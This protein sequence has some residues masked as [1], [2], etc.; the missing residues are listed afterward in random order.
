MMLRVQEKGTHV[1][2]ASLFYTVMGVLFGVYFVVLKEMGAHGA[3]LSG[4]INGL[5]FVVTLLCI[6]RPSLR[7]TFRTDMLK[8]SMK[9]S[10]PMIPQ[11]LGSI[12][13][14]YVDKLILGL[15]VPL[16]MIGLY[17]IADRISVLLRV[18]VN[19]FGDAVSPNFMRE[20][21]EDKAA[22]VAKYKNIITKW[23]VVISCAYLVLALFTEELIKIMTPAQYHSAYVFVPILLGAYI[24]KGL[25]NFAVSTVMFEKKTLVIPVMSFTAGICNAV[26]NLLL[27][28]R[29]GTIAAAWTTL[30]S[31]ILYFLLAFYFSNRY[32]PLKY[33]WP[34]L[35]KIFGSMLA[36]LFAVLSLQQDKLWVNLVIKCVGVGLFVA[37]LAKWDDGKI[38]DDARLI[39]RMLLRKPDP[40]APQEKH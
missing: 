1:M 27:I 33:D 17:S 9:Y 28:P 21:V 22:V 30:G 13:Y 16:A 26:L 29:Y 7:R 12:L 19:S 38:M 39:L 10:L 5:L 36:V 32:Y 14:L 18:V 24:F 8:S 40:D 31:Y 15:Y 6:I 23:A 4:A 2:W 20:S 11:A 25:Y 34:R 37:L 3:L 35:F